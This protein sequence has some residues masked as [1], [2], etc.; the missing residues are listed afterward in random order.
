MSGYFK[1]IHKNIVTVAADAIVTSANRYPIAEALQN[2][3]FMKRQAT[4]TYFRSVRKSV[5]LLLAR[6][7]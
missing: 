7:L 5:S 2:R 6:S 4:R 1:I 3:S